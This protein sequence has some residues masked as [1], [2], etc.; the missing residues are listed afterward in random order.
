MVQRR[1]RGVDDRWL[2]LNRLKGMRPVFLEVSR[3]DN[4]GLGHRVFEDFVR[5]VVQTQET[6]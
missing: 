5:N 2:R 1:D 4:D 3:L 6:L